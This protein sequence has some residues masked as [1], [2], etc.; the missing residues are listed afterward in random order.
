M[1]NPRLY[2][3]V[4][5]A[6]AYPKAKRP[7]CAFLLHRLLLGVARNRSIMTG[8][9]GDRMARV[10]K[11][12]GVVLLRIVAVLTA[13]F[14]FSSQF[15]CAYGPA[16][17]YGPAPTTCSSNDECNSDAGFVCDQ[18]SDGGPGHCVPVDGGTP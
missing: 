12:G 15:A 10:G 4:A 18:P 14:G 11:A 5:G 16:V 9:G 6:A 17:M 8:V 7:Q 2:S 13:L 1:P 3:A